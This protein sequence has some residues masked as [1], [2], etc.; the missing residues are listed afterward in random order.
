[1]KK[2]LCHLLSHCGWSSVLVNLS[3]LDWWNGKSGDDKRFTSIVA[4]IGLLT[5]ML[6]MCYLLV[7]SC[8]QC[9]MVRARYSVK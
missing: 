8:Y 1:M 6:L 9:M 5:S 3:S 7:Y 2:L 4:F